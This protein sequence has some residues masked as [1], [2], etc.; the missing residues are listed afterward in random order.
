[1]TYS[2]RFSSHLQ[3]LNTL[4][5]NEAG[6]IEKVLIILKGKEFHIPKYNHSP[7]RRIELVRMCF[8][9]PLS[10]VA[11]D[12]GISHYSL[13]KII[14]E[15]IGIVKF[16]DDSLFSDEDMNKSMMKSYDYCQRLIS[17]H[18]DLANVVLSHH[19]QEIILDLPPLRRLVDCLLESGSIKPL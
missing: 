9:T 12:Q 4:F 1:E 13:I 7:E 3:S 2:E 19:L 8:N 6:I 17:E 14:D 18:G 11:H 15:I 16:I 5:T 10:V